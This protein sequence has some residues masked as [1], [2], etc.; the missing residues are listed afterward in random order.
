MK[1]SE[2]LFT[3]LLTKFESS[4]ITD[5]NI[6][7]CI[8]MIESYAKQHTIEFFKHQV[9]HMGIMGKSWL[10]QDYDEWS[11]PKEKDKKITWGT[12]PDQD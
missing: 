3:E 12:F 6:Q 4:E 10:M 1:Q 11:S 5:E 8:K 2:R 9:G 7:E